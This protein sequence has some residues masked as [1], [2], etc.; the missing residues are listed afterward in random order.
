MK[1]RIMAIQVGTDV[2]MLDIEPFDSIEEAKDY[3]DKSSLPYKEY[4]IV[5]YYRKF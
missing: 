3:I 1:Y 4:V 2:F 5:P